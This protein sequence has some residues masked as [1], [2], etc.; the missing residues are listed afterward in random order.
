ML[1][2]K[3]G[4]LETYFLRESYLP[5]S[6]DLSY[7]RR[8]KKRTDVFSFR[9]RCKC[10][11]R[12][13]VSPQSPTL[14]DYDSD[15]FYFEIGKE[16][17]PT[18]ISNNISPLNAACNLGPRKWIPTFEFLCRFDSVKTK[19][20][21]LERSGASKQAQA[22]DLS[23]FFNL[24]RTRNEIQ[25]NFQFPNVKWNGKNLT[26]G[27]LPT[28]ATVALLQSIR[29][30][31]S[32]ESENSLKLQDH[33]KDLCAR[34]KRKGIN[35]SGKSKG[36]P[37]KTQKVVNSTQDED[38]LILPSDSIIISNNL[39]I[40]KNN[41]D[42]YNSKL[43][44]REK[45]DNI[46]KR[47]RG[48]FSPTELDEEYIQDDDEQPEDIVRFVILDVTAE[49]H[50]S[51]KKQIAAEKTSCTHTADVNI[52]TYKIYIPLDIQISKN[53]RSERI[54]DLQGD[55]HDDDE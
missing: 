3:F 17:L 46:I 29:A 50:E 53:R 11:D 16:I 18:V 7:V 28:S 36:F 33:Q 19:I 21:E 9:L 15:K 32:N 49:Q 24:F 52:P 1:S 6:M 51:V 54:S 47:L 44:R 40:T 41:N 13:Y 26:N 55:D 23:T 14:T 38:V 8:C 2:L 10:Q 12:H 34:K 39:H 35:V 25:S 27:I 48:I 22:S 4:A 43:T 20:E 31:S 42:T 45:S 30:N 37:E 5:F